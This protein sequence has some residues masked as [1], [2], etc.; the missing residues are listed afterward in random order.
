MKKFFR[1][2]FLIGF[3]AIV[4]LVVLFFGIQFLKGINIFH[5]ANY[6]FARYDNVEGLAIS[7]PVT[8]NGFKV[9]QVREINYD[10]S[11]PGNVI[12]E[13]SLDRELRLPQGSVAKVST[14]LLGTASIVLS[15]GTDNSYYSPGD[16]VRAAKDSGLMGSVTQ[17]LL[18]GVS[19]I[20]PKIDTLL[21]NL[22]TLTGDA[23]LVNSVKRL[24]AITAQLEASSRE[25]TVM[26]RNLAPVT[27]N[28][29]NIA[30]N[31]DRLTGDLAGVSAQVA[32]APIDSIMRNLEQTSAQL[33]S[34][35][36]Q[37]NDPNSSLGLLMN[38]PKLYNNINATVVS[39]DSLFTDI[40]A[41]PK[42][43]INIKV[44]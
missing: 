24:D 9:G 36:Q 35:S 43:Y 23:A 11:H 4:A 42:R 20:F 28:V 39:L 30:G 8:L 3:W 18:P 17:D 44:F 21:S 14:D 10:Y 22:N 12:V 16:T 33:H 2:E 32:G 41:H 15:L 13:L 34:L 6:Y 40:K 7:A 31:V 1:K 29:R 26:L 5:T 38:D 19:A 37:L 25:L 27:S